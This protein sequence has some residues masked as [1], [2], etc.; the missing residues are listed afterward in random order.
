MNLEPFDLPSGQSLTDAYIHRTDLGIQT[1]FGYHPTVTNDW[2]RRAEH[3]DGTSEQR[4]NPGMLA[5]A[6]LAYNR[7]FDAASRA[8]DNIQALAQG[9]LSVVGGQ[10]AGLW[11]GPLMV[12]HKAISIIQ[13]ARY[14]QEQLGRPVVPIF[15]IAGEDH[16]WDEAAHTYIADSEPSLRKLQLSRPGIARTS[17]SRTAIASDSWKSALEEL[18]S[19]LPDSEAKP[20][21][22]GRLQVMASRCSTLSEFFADILSWLFKSEGLILMDADDPAIRRLESPMFK[23]MIEENERLQHAY[24]DAASE[25]KK[26]GYPLQVELAGSSANLFWFDQGEGN[27]GCGDRILLFKNGDTFVD[28]KGTISLKQEQLLDYAANHPER[29]SNNVLTRP[30]MQD[31]LFP[32][33]AAVLGPGEIAYW[34][35]TGKAFQ[36]F[37]ME[38][39][40]VVPRMSFT[41]VDRTAQKHMKRYA[42]SFEDIVYRFEERK[43]EWLAKQEELSLDEEFEHAKQSMMKIYEPLLERM[44]SVWPGL[45]PLGQKNIRKI[46]EQIE[47]MKSRVHDDIRK[48]HDVSIRQLD[49]LRLNLYPGGKPQ[50]RIINFTYYYNQY[51]LD[52]LDALLTAT[53]DLKGGHRILYL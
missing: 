22:F 18:H 45:G 10:Q 35:L 25:V 39:P 53:I 20:E 50:E 2:R 28:R 24:A 40:I 47:F 13:S 3:L 41:I 14:A 30:L 7:R 27:D 17:I 44:T 29:L 49:R 32:V 5:E 11:S 15:W 4:V 37:G 21:L 12:I 16:D 46:T 26:L 34:S 42:L 31:Y 36:Q 19:V 48:R 43:E 6:L 52:W 51:G 9:A 23:R 1:L 33:L 8:I 38:M